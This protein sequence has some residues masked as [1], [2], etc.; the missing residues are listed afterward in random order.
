M[1]LK[2]WLT[3]T[4][5]SNDFPIGGTEDFFI[6]KKDLFDDYEDEFEEGGLFKTW[7]KIPNM[8][9]ECK[10]VKLET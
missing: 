7:N 1:I 6:T 3:N 9:M 5:T 2:N 4:K 8:V 10:I